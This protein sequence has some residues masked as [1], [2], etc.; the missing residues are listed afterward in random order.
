MSDTT[1]LTHHKR[2]HTPKAEYIGVERNNTLPSTTRAAGGF[3]REHREE[4]KPHMMN[5]GLQGGAFKKDTTPERRH[6]PI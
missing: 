6:R 1:A 2:A 4:V 5:R 3:S